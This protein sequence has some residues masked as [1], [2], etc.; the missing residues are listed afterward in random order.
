[1]RVPNN[2]IFVRT[3]VHVLMVVICLIFAACTGTKISNSPFEKQLEAPV[4]PL[5]MLNADAVIRNSISTI[6]LYSSEKATYRVKEAVTILNR[7]GRDKGRLLLFYD[8]FREVDH[9][10]GVVRDKNGRIIRSLDES[11]MRDFSATSSYSLYDDTRVKVVELFYNRYPYTIEYDYQITYSG[12]LNLPAWYPQGPGESVERA[13]LIVREYGKNRI[14]YKTRNMD[15]DPEINKLQDVQTYKWELKNRP[16]RSLKPYG[17]HSRDQLPGVIMAPNEFSID[18]Y[19]GSFTSWQSFGKWY[20]QLGENTRTLPSELQQEIDRL[21]AGVSS[22]REMVEILYGYLQQEMRYVS[23]QLGIGGWKPFDVARVYRTKYGDCKAL[24]NFMQAILEYAGIEAYPVLLRSGVNEPEVISD[25]PSNQFNHVVLL[26][27]LGDEGKIWLECTSKYIPPGHLGFGN[28]G[29][30]GL[31]IAES[32]S[33]LITTPL[34]TEDENKSESRYTLTFG[35][36]GKVVLESNNTYSGAMQDYILSI[37]SPK[38]SQDRARWLREQLDYSVSDLQAFTMNEDHKN[39]KVFYRLTTPGLATVASNRLF[40]S[41][42]KITENRNSMTVDTDREVQVILP[43]LYSKEESIVIEIPTGY[44]IESL[45]EQ[46][47]LD[48]PFASYSYSFTDSENSRLVIHRKVAFKRREISS[49][50]FEALNEFWKR[51]A[52]TER[53]NIVFVRTN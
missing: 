41:I 4:N 18:E 30:T 43:M 24:T 49:E 51:I 1:M 37:L 17:P 22:K 46:L 39:T 19:R 29:K 27:D 34:G 9:I 50:H 35:N 44:R 52:S 20:Y 26:V 14:R 6:H 31:M 53:D 16:P 7:D 42:D 25:F 36:R 8:K 12:L 28:Q 23:I 32:G 15:I 2:R 38:S 5:L 48:Y 47:S 11:D 21:V 45:P 33:D 10:K 3:V 13:S 40:L